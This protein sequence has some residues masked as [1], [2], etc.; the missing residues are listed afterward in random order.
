M[1]YFLDT[2]FIED[3][4]IAIQLISIGIVAEDGRE[5]YLVS[6]EFDEFW[7]NDWVKEHV[8]PKL[9]DPQFRVSK[10]TIKEKILEFVGDDKPI[11]WGYFSDY[12]WVVFCQLF[13]KMVDLPKGWPMFCLDLKQSMFERR[14]SK[15]SL[16]PQSKYAH[17]A[18]ADA[19][20]IEQAHE[21]VYK[22]NQ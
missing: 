15:D 20:W 5:L 18:L 22:E 21:I 12:D 8:L 7:A 11:F 14:I 17:H 13:G 10:Q 4:R 19:S 16:P 9:I 1:K 2:E 3:P 6:N